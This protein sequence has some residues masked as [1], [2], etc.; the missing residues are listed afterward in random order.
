MAEPPGHGFYEP[1]DRTHHLDFRLAAWDRT[2]VSVDEVTGNA[3]VV[4]YVDGVGHI[5]KNR[6]GK[7][8]LGVKPT[9]AAMEDGT[10]VVVWANEGSRLRVE[11]F[12]GGVNT[13]FRAGE[14]SVS[15]D[16]VPLKF[17]RGV[18]PWEG[19]AAYRVSS[20]DDSALVV[21][22]GGESFQDVMGPSH[23]LREATAKPMRD[24]EF[25]DGVVLHR[26]GPE[27]L[28]VAL[29][30][31]GPLEK[32]DVPDGEAMRST[33]PDGAGSIILAH[34]RT[35]ERAL[36]LVRVDPDDEIQRVHD[37]YEDLLQSRVRTPEPDIDETFRA[38]IYNL[39]Y[40]W[41][42]PYGWNEAIHHWLSFWHN[43]HTAAAE[44]LGQEDRSRLVSVFH[45]ENLHPSGS[46]PQFF[47]DGTRKREFGGSNQ[48]FAW[49]VR[50]FWN[51]TADEEFAQIA[52]DAM[53]RVIHQTLT[54]HDA[55]GNGLI[56]WDLQVG[57][58]E[59]F[60]QFHH[61]ATT[62]S[63]EL[64]NMMRTRVM[65]ARG[66]GDEETAVRWEGMISRSMAALRESLWL[67]DLGRFGN[68]RDESGKIR[69]DAQYHAYLY[70]S[71]WD[72]V[73]ELDGY[74]S[75]RHVHDNLTGADGRVYVSN[76]FPN[77]WQGSWGMQAGGQQQPWAAWAYSKAGQRNNAYRPLLGIAEIVNGDTLRGAWPEVA[78]PTPDYFTPPAGLFIA[79]VTEAIF[80]LN[81]YKPKGYLLVS[82]AFPDHWPDAEINLPRFSA[83]YTRSGNTVSYTVNSEEELP[84]R[85]RWSL[86]PASISTVTAN[87]VPLDHTIT[88]GVN[89]LIVEADV[90]AAT[91]TEFVISYTPIE[92]TVTHHGSVAEGQPLTVEVSGTEPIGI[93]DRLGVLKSSNISGNQVDVVLRENLLEPYTHY[94]RLGMG[95]FSRR[96]FFIQCTS[97]HGDIWLPVDFTLLPP[98]E[99]GAPEEVTVEDGHLVANL[100]LRNNT[101]SAVNGTGW[102][103]AAG[104]AFPVELELPARS[105]T[106]TPVQIPGAYIARFSMG[107]NRATFSFP[108]DQKS[109]LILSITGAFQS[110]DAL[111]DFAASRLEHITIPLESTVPGEEWMQLRPILHGAPLPWPGWQ[112][113]FS[114]ELDGVTSLESTDIPGLTF[115]F[116]PN[117]WVTIGE[118]AGKPYH[119]VDL[120]EGLYRKFHLLL[121]TFADN[122]DLYSRLANIIVRDE[123]TVVAARDLYMP[124]DVDW[125]D[126]NGWA[127][128]MDILRDGRPDRLGMMPFMEPQHAHFND[129]S[130]V[131]A[132]IPHI[133][134]NHQHWSNSRYIRTDNVTFNIVEIDLGQVRTV[135]NLAI[136]ADGISPGFALLGITAERVGDMD[137]LE[138]TPFEPPADFMEPMTIFAFTGD[139]GDLADWK[140]EGDAFTVSQAFGETYSLNSRNQSGENTSGRALSPNFAVDSNFK[141]LIIDIA[142]SAAETVDGEP[143]LAVY[144]VDGYGG[145]RIRTVES[146]GGEGV[147]ERVV[148]LEGLR[149]HLVRVEVV[150]KGSE[151]DSGWVGL[152]S[153]RANL[154]RY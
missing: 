75:L 3:G 148:S 20:S 111:A 128:S 12:P 67:N 87:G 152:V 76:S 129:T 55:L 1:D 33:F 102:L 126:P 81:M 9:G 141:E 133:F 103:H 37:Y 25:E 94:G 90:P 142:G 151:G 59:D 106:I 36:E 45:A 43:Q 107:D 41:L 51:F 140:V 131:G 124:G 138:G 114:G 104:R 91:S 79:S 125:W 146:P 96:T 110:S 68:Y 29:R 134:P 16:L 38:A 121:A 65:L 18:K 72:I 82:P 73:D 130:P 119:R 70:P 11:D 127:G 63:I 56:A 27:S 6:L 50:H 58:Q 21:E 115:S 62:P 145:N 26:A 95:T 17:G 52:G 143:N 64:I 132:W 137:L 105:E 46:V 139:E 71:L 112:Q 24:L 15:A 69:L 83:E 97:P 86:P 113:P 34:A 100:V 80:G 98:M 32:M 28:Y 93:S 47:T 57:N 61:D 122:H 101:E 54:Q 10:P 89:R 5:G 49:Q 2:I 116:H 153:V 108:N 85:L 74:T 31:T 120:E 99:A 88:P 8:R 23:D 35:R 149:N 30:S 118:R 84:R 7:F 78:G 123:Y 150:D 147:H 92:A 4:S 135:R 77:H 42:A 154:L 14:V 53:E 40:N 19:V 109:N 60:I 13:S 144:L 44:W 117:R 22:I 66:V 39:E 136:Q 48:F